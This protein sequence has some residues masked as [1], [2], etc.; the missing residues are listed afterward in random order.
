MEIRNPKQ[1]YNRSRWVKTN[2]Y[3]ITSVVSSINESFRGTG[4]VTEPARLYDLRASILPTLSVHISNPRSLCSQLL[5]TIHIKEIFWDS[6]VAQW[7]SICLQLRVLPGPWDCVPH[8]APHRDP[9][10]SSVY[11]AASLCVAHE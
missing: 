5:L 4:N 6:W 10:S 9:A 1:I 7:L 2:K 8:Q 11:V 3:T